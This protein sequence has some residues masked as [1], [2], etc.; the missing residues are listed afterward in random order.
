M[1]IYLDNALSVDSGSRASRNRNRG[2]IE[3][4]AR[5]ILELHTVGAGSVYSQRDVIELARL[6]TGWTVPIGRNTIAAIAPLVL[7][8]NRHDSGAKTILGALYDDGLA[9]GERAL[10]NRALRPE[11]AQFLATEMAHHFLER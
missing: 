10:H 6:I 5:E 1:L 7:A 2:L 4:L 11:T 8:A 9:Q 3:N